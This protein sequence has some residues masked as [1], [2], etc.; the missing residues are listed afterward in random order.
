M[1]APYYAR[2]HWKSQWLVKGPSSFVLT[3]MTER[4]ARRVAAVLNEEHAETANKE[5]SHG[6]E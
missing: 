4:Q 5:S 3:G 2:Q 1:S 6:E